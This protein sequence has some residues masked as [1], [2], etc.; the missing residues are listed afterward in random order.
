VAEPAPRQQQ[1]PPPVVVDD[2]SAEEAA[3][4]AAVAAASAA[5]AARVHKSRSCYICKAR[6]HQLHHF[7]SDLCPACA[8]LNFSKRNQTAPLLGKFALLTGGRVKIGFHC[9]LKLLRCGATLV[10]G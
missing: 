5:S 9:G 4:A 2:I 1:Q 8:A 6:Y 7:Y 10:G 3:T